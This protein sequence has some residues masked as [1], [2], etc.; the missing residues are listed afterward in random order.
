MGLIF[1]QGLG[2]PENLVAA[3]D[4]SLQRGQILYTVQSVDFSWGVLHCRHFL[5]LLVSLWYNA[6]AIPLTGP[7]ARRMLWGWRPAQKS[8]L[9]RSSRRHGNG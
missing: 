3:D 4:V 5:A 7:P 1:I 2:S 6:E 9:K 8:I